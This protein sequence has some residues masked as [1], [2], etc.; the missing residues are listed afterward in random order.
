[1]SK[2]RSCPAGGDTA[3]HSRTRATALRGGDTSTL[4]C[5]ATVFPQPHCSPEAQQHL[6]SSCTP[7]PPPTS[8][9][10][11]LL[12][13]P[14]RPTLTRNKQEG[15]VCSPGLRARSSVHPLPGSS[16]TGSSA[17]RSRLPQQPLFYAE[18]PCLKNPPESGVHGYILLSW[19]ADV[20]K[21]T[22]GNGTGAVNSHAG[23]KLSQRPEQP[24]APGF[25]VPSDGVTTTHRRTAPC[26]SSSPSHT[27]P[28]PPAPG[29][30]AP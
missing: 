15:T 1:M 3:G 29:D 30:N 4:W 9:G 5:R 17:R 23:G 24:P 2:E 26:P 10:F 18:I 12:A 6:C 20:P 13:T 28:S 7:E 11:L 25:L 19:V 14:Q 21:D 16:G 22:T 8:P 27:G